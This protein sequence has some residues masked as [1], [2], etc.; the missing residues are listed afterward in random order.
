[1]MTV[2]ALAENPVQKGN[3]MLDGSSTAGFAKAGGD[4]NKVGEDS[5]SMINISPALAYFF[6]DGVAVGAVVVFER[7]TLGDT[8]E[9]GFHFGPMVVWFPTGKDA[10]DPKGKLLPFVMGSFRLVSDKTSYPDDGG[11][12][13]K[14]TAVAEDYSKTTGWAARFE[15]GGQWMVSNGV[16][17]HL[18]AYFELQNAKF[19]SEIGGTEFE[20]DSFSGNEF[21]VNVGVTGFFG[22]GQ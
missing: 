22:L 11:G 14:S 5:P 7:W 1:M 20:S 2:C 10:M 4:L 16:G 3:W 9:T 19:K 12:F 8:K 13:A 6:A 15:G 18:G 17:I 21:G